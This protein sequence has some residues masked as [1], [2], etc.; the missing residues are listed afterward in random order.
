MHIY[1]KIWDIHIKE[2]FFLFK[3]EHF[4]IKFISSK[5]I[6]PHILKHVCS[7]I[8]LDKVELII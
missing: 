8:R 6:G 4:T 5:K 7:E 2:Q 1:L 3:I